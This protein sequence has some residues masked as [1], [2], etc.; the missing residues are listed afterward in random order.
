[1]SR[2]RIIIVGST[3]AVILAVVG[4]ALL[5][6]STLSP[7]IS[8]TE[9]SHTSKDGATTVVYGTSDIYVPSDHGLLGAGLC[10]AALFVAIMTVRR[11]RARGGH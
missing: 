7:Q 2:K 5:W 9:T 11:A 6:M 1:V 8:A 10:V 3:S 4:V